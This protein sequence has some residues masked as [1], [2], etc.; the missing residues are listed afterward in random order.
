MEKILELKGLTK[1]FGNKTVVDN[2]SFDILPGEIC[3]FLGPNG[4]GK[5]TTI[6]MISGLLYADKGEIN[7][8]GYSVRTDFEKALAN[9]GAIVENPENYLE[10]TGRMN[11]ALAA[12]INNI[13][14]AKQNEIIKQ[15]GLENRIDEKT[16][17]YS[18][19]MKQ[20]LGIAI[21][22]INSPKLLIFDE[23]TNGLDPNGIK[24]F[25]ETLKRLAHEE[26]AGV[27][28]S[29]HMMSEMEILCDKVVMIEKGKLIDIKN[30][31][32]IKNVAE[33]GRKSTYSIVVSD[34]IKAQNIISEQISAKLVVKEL[35]ES[36]LFEISADV[37]AEMVPHIVK[38]LVLNDIEIWSVHTKEGTLEDAYMNAMEGNAI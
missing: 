33:K 32:D 11:I 3:G 22:L 4:S 28:V 36:G 35:K 34:G 8:C 27:L 16:K 30:I 17:K 20:R 15:V 29:S 25:R 19:G 2:L 1:S 13:S 12:R 26:G 7:I 37:N 38:N 10:F 31:N 18:L 14:V 24:D 23:P 9:V 5:T 21:A 6:K